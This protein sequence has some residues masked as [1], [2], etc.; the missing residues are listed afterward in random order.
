M[1]INCT[2]MNIITFPQKSYNPTSSVL[3]YDRRGLIKLMAHFPTYMIYTN[4]K[5]ACHLHCPIYDTKQRKF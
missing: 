1:K 5:I 4:R 2:I 3:T